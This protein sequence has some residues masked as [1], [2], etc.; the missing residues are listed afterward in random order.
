MLCGAM[1]YYGI[2][3]PWREAGYFETA[4]RRRILRGLDS[5]IRRGGLI[6]LC[7]IVGCGKSTLL[8]R[9]RAAL[10]QE[11]KILVSR[12]LA[13]EKVDLASLI[14]ALFYDL[15]GGN[16]VKV[17][18]RPQLREHRLLSLIAQ[19]A[20][21][22]ALF[23]DHA[24]DLSG[25]TLVQLKHLIEVVREAGESLSVVLAVQPK[26]KNDI[27]NPALEEIGAPSTLMEIAGLGG[28]QEAYVRWL[29]GQCATQ[30]AKSPIHDE[31]IALLAERLAT[32]LQIE[33][34]LALAF[35]QGYAIAQRPV[36]AG[37]VDS[38]LNDL[39]PR[40]ARHGDKAGDPART[41]AGGRAET[42]QE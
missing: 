27:A 36:S 25:R 29:L 41:L 35:E 24:H 39:E 4:H 13:V 22:V 12:S 34:A 3:R 8:A 28:E 18:T 42:R 9:I 5:A 7:G 20:K 17:P 21:P 31:A 11:G 23:V 33:H 1:G 6:A 30:E 40:P 16:E 15:T 2:T 38:V 14:T 26:L 19:R 32:P 10:R 37:L